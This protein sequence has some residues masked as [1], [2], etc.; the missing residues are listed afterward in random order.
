MRSNLFLN[1]G[2]LTLLSDILLA[3]LPL[4]LSLFCWKLVLPTA[5]VTDV[6]T[7]GV[8][9]NGGVIPNLRLKHST[10]SFAII[11]YTLSAALIKHNGYDNPGVNKA[12]DLLQWCRDCR[13]ANIDKRA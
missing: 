3:G 6:S 7:D 1:A 2:G 9:D 11:S 10:D 5:G 13:R 12:L 4:F 8:G